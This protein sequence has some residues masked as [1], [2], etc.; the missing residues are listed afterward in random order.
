MSSIPAPQSPSQSKVQPEREGRRPT[1]TITTNKK[2][3]IDRQVSFL[4]GV[5]TA[6]CAVRQAPRFLDSSA[7][8]PR[9]LLV[10]VGTCCY[11]ST[12]KPGRRSSAY[13][14]LA[15]TLGAILLV[16]TLSF[17][18]KVRS[19]GSKPNAQQDAEA[20]RNPLQVRG[21]RLL[22]LP[23]QRLL[24]RALATRRDMVLRVELL[25]K[26]KG[27]LLVDACHCL[28]PCLHQVWVV[29]ICG[30]LWGPDLLAGS[31]HRPLRAA[32]LWYTGCQQV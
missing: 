1:Q 9:H 14:P 25:L 24:Q 6:Y 11:P 2:T 13:M 12:P 3:Q 19:R 5:V 27:C 15:P 30:V 20:T 32:A 16:A 18:T 29:H 7:L 26:Q 17:L 23:L 28:P 31:L 8:L 4:A 10:C 21:S 22:L